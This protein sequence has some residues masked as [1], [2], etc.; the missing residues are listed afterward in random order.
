MTKSLKVVTTI[1]ASIAGLSLLCAMIV[2]CVDVIMRYVFHD[3]L[4]WSQELITLYLLPA[5]FF[6][7]LPL[8]MLNNRHVRLDIITN[9]LS[10]KSLIA[11][12]IASY[13]AIV[14]ILVALLGRSVLITMNS[15]ADDKVYMGYLLWP[16]WLEDIMVPIGFAV[17]LVC[18]VNRM[19]DLALRWNTGDA[20]D[21]KQ[22]D[23]VPV[24]EKIGDVDPNINN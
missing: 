1:M 24:I 14:V 4:G 3:P 17:L 23:D 20:E 18:V 11:L 9:L 5:S 22:I 21:I 19:K 10:K 15:F 16:V 12:G 7:A 6:L 8:S 2:T 13:L